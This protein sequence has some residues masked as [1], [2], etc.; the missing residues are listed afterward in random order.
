MPPRLHWK[1]HQI[2]NLENCGFE[3]RRRHIVVDLLPP[4]VSP[5]PRCPKSGGLVQFQSGAPH[6]LVV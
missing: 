3:S 5:W 6:A 1:W 2:P 4:H